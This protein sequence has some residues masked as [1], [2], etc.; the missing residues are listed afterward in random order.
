[1]TQITT[2]ASDV[3]ERIIFEVRPTMIPAIV[4]FEN[5]TL[6]GMVVLIGLFTMVF[7]IGPMEIGIISIAYFLLAFPSFRQIF[8]AGSTTYV[9]TNRRI[10]VF[11]AGI[12]Q[13][14]QSFPLNEIDSARCR[15]SGLQGFY[16]AGDILLYRRGLRKP[17]RLL[18]LPQCR[19]HAEQINKAVANFNR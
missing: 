12:K 8:M 16:G 1:V 19:Q 18:A 5:L 10:V 15:P 6:I 11:M 7:R 3:K 14:E 13:Q 2:I 17:V 9:L 4:T